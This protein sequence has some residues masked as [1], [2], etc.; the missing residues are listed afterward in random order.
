M[1]FTVPAHRRRKHGG[2]RHVPPHFLPCFDFLSLLNIAIGLGAARP[3]NIVIR[4]LVLEG[5]SLAILKT[6]KYLYAHMMINAD[7]DSEPME[8]VSGRTIVDSLWTF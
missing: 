8:S 1:R 4:Q 5:K 7:D 3:G 6:A 2:Q